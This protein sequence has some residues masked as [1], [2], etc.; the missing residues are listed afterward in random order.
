MEDK[1]RY[2]KNIFYLDVDKKLMYLIGHV[3]NRWE[4][5]EIGCIETDI[6]L[7]DILKTPIP[8]I[9]RHIKQLRHEGFLIVENSGKP[10]QRIL[11]PS[12]KLLELLEVK[13][14][15]LINVKS[16][17]NDTLILTK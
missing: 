8:T 10:G 14:N 17:K 1:A 4:A 7:A 3:F 13:T 12:K 2:V 16:I 6:K 11:K 15:N 9:K 5:K